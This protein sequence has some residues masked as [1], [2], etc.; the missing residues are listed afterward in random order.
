MNGIFSLASA[1]VHETSVFVLLVHYSYIY[2]SI[3]TN[4]CPHGCI[5]LCHTS[6]EISLHLVKISQFAV[7]YSCICRYLQAQHHMHHHHRVSVHGWSGLFGLYFSLVWRSV[8]LVCKLDTTLLH[9][10]TRKETRH[11]YSKFTSRVCVDHVSHNL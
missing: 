9:A 8:G 11:K 7:H 2:L 4:V 10:C 3:S 1:H 5:I 6:H